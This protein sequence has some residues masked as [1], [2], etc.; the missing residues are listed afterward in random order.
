MY[1]K[2]LT[3][4]NLL[5][6]GELLIVLK[7]LWLYRDDAFIDLRKGTKTGVGQFYRHRQEPVPWVSRWKNGRCFR[8]PR[9][10]NERRA[11]C[12]ADTPK[13]ILENHGL[14]F[15]VRPKRSP[16][17]LPTTYDDIFLR[18]QRSWKEYRRT[19]RKVVGSIN[20][21]MHSPPIWVEETPYG[22]LNRFL[23]LR[24]WE[25]VEESQ[26]EAVRIRRGLPEAR[27]RFSS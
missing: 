24:L 21:R 25:D 12:A 19:Q 15:K 11:N 27:V 14:A 6:R 9:T 26:V 23:G 17:R 20:R 3:N 10:T 7:C 13:E 1:I 16:H 18:H 2:K 8:H 4:S 22:D 5:E